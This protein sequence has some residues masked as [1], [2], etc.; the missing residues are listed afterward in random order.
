VSGYWRR[1]FPE[2]VDAPSDPRPAAGAPVAPAAGSVD[3]GR[4]GGTVVV[5]LHGD[6]DRSRS[7]T[8]ASTLHD[9]EVG[10]IDTSGVDVL[11]VAADRIGERGGELRLGGP[12]GAVFDALVLTGLARLIDIPFELE[13]RPWAAGRATRQAGMSSHPAGKARFRHE[14]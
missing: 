6:L 1:P 11:G 2:P 9:I 10:R 14:E 7:A 8:L 4:Y 13:H 5:T 12:T 3:T